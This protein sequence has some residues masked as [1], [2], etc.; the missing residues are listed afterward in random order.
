[1]FWTDLRRPDI[2][3]HQMIVVPNGS[4]SFR[5]QIRCSIRA[6]SCDVA[7]SLLANDALH[8]ISENAH[9]II[10]RHHDA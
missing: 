4:C 6:Y 5:R 1:M 8:V 9:A 10:P 2:G 3:E 7:Q